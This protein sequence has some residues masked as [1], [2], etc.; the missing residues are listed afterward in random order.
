MDSK[1]DAIQIFPLIKAFLNSELMASVLYTKTGGGCF[2]I[3]L[4]IE[5]MDLMALQ[6]FQCFHPGSAFAFKD[7]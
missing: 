5:W 2:Y 7:Q 3:P 6:Q 4:K 1:S